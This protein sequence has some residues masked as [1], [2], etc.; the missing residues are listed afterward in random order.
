MYMLVSTSKPNVQSS[1]D[2]SLRLCES[3]HRD[4]AVLL[5][6]ASASFGHYALLEGCDGLLGPLLCVLFPT[7]DRI[8]C[9]GTDDR[10]A[11]DPAEPQRNVPRGRD[12]ALSL[13]SFS[14]E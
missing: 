1:T 8:A 3:Q 14:L 5:E 10:R 11:A 7:G 9:A 4:N 13:D 6:A 12:R 2:V